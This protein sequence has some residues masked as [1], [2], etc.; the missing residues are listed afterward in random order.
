[1]AELSGRDCSDSIGCDSPV[2]DR[3]GD[4]SVV[5]DVQGVAALEARPHDVPGGVADRHLAAARPDPGLVDL[6]HRRRKDEARPAAAAS[7]ESDEMAKD[8]EL[9]ARAAAA[10]KEAA[11]A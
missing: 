4:E 11:A 10:A 2:D 6:T 5:H 7:R 8:N 3:A 1:R 9:Q